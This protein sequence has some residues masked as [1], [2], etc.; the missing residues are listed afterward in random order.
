MLKLYN[1]LIKPNKTLFSIVLRTIR[2]YHNIVSTLRGGLMKIDLNNPNIM[3]A[4]DA[5]EIWGHAKNYVRRTYKN[6]PSKF[7]KGSIRKFGKQWVVTTEGMET[8]TG[9]KDP[10]KKG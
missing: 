2:Y 1:Y 7:P 4:G 6:E 10:R 3:D 5:S 8:I 9:V